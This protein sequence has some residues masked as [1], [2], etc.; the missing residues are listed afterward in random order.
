MNFFAR[1]A[2][3]DS[4]FNQEDVFL[5]LDDPFVNMDQEKIAIAGKILEEISSKRQILY[6]TCHTSRKV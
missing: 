2:L 4:M 6:F 3:V 5:V 1:L